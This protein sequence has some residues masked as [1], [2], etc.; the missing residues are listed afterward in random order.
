MSTRGIRWLDDH[1][2]AHRVVEYL[3]KQKGAGR[4]A[5][6]IG[7]A[8]ELVVKSL[9]LEAGGD[10]RFALL[11]ADRELSLKKLAR[12]WGLREVQLAAVRDAERV[13]GYKEGG[14]SPLGSWT[15]LPV[16]MDEALFEH[17]EILVNGGHRGV[18]VGLDPWA[19]QELLDAAVEDISA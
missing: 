14:I 10:L 3:Y 5:A 7:M 12:L 1:H 16:V 15:A 4:A 2:V 17:A 8:E 13:T 6:A 18:L 11:A 9:V 19:L